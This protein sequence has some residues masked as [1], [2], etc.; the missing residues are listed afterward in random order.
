MVTI[1]FITVP[2]LGEAGTH[3]P[4]RCLVNLTERPKGRD[5]RGLGRTTEMSR[6]LES[7]PNDRDVETFGVFPERLRCRNLWSLCRT[8]EMSR[9]LES[10]PNDRDVET[11]GVFPER[12]RCRD[13]WSLDRTTEMSR[14]LE[15][16][17]NDWDVET[18]GV[19]AERLRCRDH[20]YLADG[21]TP[22]QLTLKPRSVKLI[23]HQELGNATLSSTHLDKQAQQGRPTRIV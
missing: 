14:P 7:L 23:H 4:A 3:L 15:S 9:P 8:T 21:R 22:F 20:G 17:P 11:F 10:F 13:L 1:F 6:P 12:R 19:L 2:V 18:F 16:W 5:L